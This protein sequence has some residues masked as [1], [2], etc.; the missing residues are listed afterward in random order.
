VSTKA[1][2]NPHKHQP[3]IIPAVS[4]LG[5]AGLGHRGGVLRDLIQDPASEFPRRPIPRTPV[6]KG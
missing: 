5:K 4:S 3:R 2:E 1:S 6:N